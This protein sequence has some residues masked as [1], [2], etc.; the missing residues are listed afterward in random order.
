MDFS[1]IEKSFLG[2]TKKSSVSHKLGWIE[3]VGPF[4]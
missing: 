2:Q 4:A 1:L 3:G